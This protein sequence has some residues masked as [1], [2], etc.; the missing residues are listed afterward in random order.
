MLLV[1]IHGILAVGARGAAPIEEAASGTIAEAGLLVEVAEN[2]GAAATPLDAA[3]SPTVGTRAAITETILPSHVRSDSLRGCFLFFVSSCCLQTS[4]DPNTHPRS[5]MVPPRY[6][7]NSHTPV[8]GARV[9]FPIIHTL[10]K[11]IFVL[12]LGTTKGGGSVHCTI[13]VGLSV[14]LLPQENS[15]SWNFVFSPMVLYVS[16]IIL[17]Y[18]RSYLQQ[19]RR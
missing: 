15:I 11:E 10:R 18:D 9:L 7:R 16:N 12:L 1:D 5:K 8:Q 17:Y 13:L 14:P 6:R 4:G 19:I 2:T 3:V